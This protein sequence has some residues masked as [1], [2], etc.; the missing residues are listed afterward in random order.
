[1]KIG[2]EVLYN[3]IWFFQIVTCS[4]VYTRKYWEVVLVYHLGVYGVEI[5]TSNLD[6]SLNFVDREG[7][8]T[9]TSEGISWE[10]SEKIALGDSFAPK[11]SRVSASSWGGKDEF[12][13]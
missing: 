11:P 8:E 10:C 13:G 2:F 1:V 7:V 12:A 5:M 9:R 3:V 4:G 6:C